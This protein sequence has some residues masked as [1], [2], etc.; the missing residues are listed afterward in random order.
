MKPA[1][2]R[3]CQ[4]DGLLNV[5]LHGYHFSEELPNIMKDSLKQV[6]HLFNFQ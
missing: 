1:S 3:Y 2:F 5:L 4:K 6:L